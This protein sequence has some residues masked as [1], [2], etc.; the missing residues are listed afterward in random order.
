M[1]YLYEVRGKRHG[2]VFSRTYF[3]SE[4]K[5]VDFFDRLILKSHKQDLEEGNVDVIDG[6]LVIDWIFKD[7]YAIYKII[8]NPL[9][10]DFQKCMYVPVKKLCNYIY[11]KSIKDI[12]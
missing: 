9:S 8:L 2:S 7:T 4:E 1:S 12:Q 3:S 6:V 11:N 10:D 5:V